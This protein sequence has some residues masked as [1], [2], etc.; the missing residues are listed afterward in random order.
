MKL[1]KRYRVIIGIVV[2]VV[3]LVGGVYLY[4]NGSPFLCIFYKYTGIYCTGCGVGRAA[5]DL[6]HFN[7]IEALGHNLLFTILLPFIAVYALLWY[8]AIITGKDILVRRFVISQKVGIA[9]LVLIVVFTV[10]RNI[11]VFP[12][13]LLS[14]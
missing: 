14:P 8:L 4:F 11:P 6:M 9:L 1:D 10:L 12:F 13:T 2:P 3:L 5:Y 7:I